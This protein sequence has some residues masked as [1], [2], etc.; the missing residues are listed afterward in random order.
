MAQNSWR[1][2][3]SVK[4]PSGTSYLGVERHVEQVAVGPMGLAH[5]RAGGTVFGGHVGSPAAAWAVAVAEGVDDG[6]KTLQ[7]IN[8]TPSR[9]EEKSS[10][11]LVHCLLFVE[12]E[13]FRNKTWKD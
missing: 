2:V 13:S 8:M 5:V 6:E 12:D 7:Y 10:F 4:S 1:R 3:G 9:E 11:L